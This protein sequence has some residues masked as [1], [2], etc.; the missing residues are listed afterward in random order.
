MSARLVPALWQSIRVTLRA[1]WRVT[2]QIFHEA[3]GALFCLFACYGAIAGWRQWKHRPTLWLM[4]F[5]FL[6]ALMMAAFGLAAFRRA[7][8]IR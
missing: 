1:L 8:R 4:A 7:R 3:M 6:Y 5:A 2:R